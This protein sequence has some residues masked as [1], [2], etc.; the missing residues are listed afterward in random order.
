MKSTEKQLKQIL[1]LNGFFS[2]TSGLVLCFGYEPIADLIR[3]KI[4]Q[5]LLYI[6]MGLILFSTT[7][8]YEAVKLTTSYKAVVSII[9]QDWLWVLGSLIII[10]LQVFNLNNTGYLLIFMVAIAVA[11]FAILQRKYL[12]KN[13]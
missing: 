1:K 11:L 5:V 6:G 8:L 10:L 9:I 13:N 4:P 12:Q 2:L 3:A 7:V